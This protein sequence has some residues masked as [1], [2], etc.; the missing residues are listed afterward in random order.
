M[1]RVRGYRLQDRIK[2]YRK[3][4]ICGQLT[5]PVN[6]TGPEPDIKV[7]WAYPGLAYPEHRLFIWGF[8]F[9]DR[10]GADESREVAIR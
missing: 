6:W 7:S 1:S 8:I 3:L 5:G 2:F 4:E 9:I 10:M